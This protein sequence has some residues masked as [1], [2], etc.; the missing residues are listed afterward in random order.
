[1]KT[2]YLLSARTSVTAGHREECYY[3]HLKLRQIAIPEFLHRR[4][5]LSKCPYMAW[6]AF[7]SIL[8]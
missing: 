2:Y 8:P 6:S 3:L 4:S 1:M 5:A 7:G